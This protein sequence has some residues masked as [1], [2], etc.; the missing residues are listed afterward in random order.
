MLTVDHFT[1]RERNI[2]TLPRRVREASCIADGVRGV[3]VAVSEGVVLLAT[4]PATATILS[5][6]LAKWLAE[7][8]EADPWANLNDALARGALEPAPVER[9][10]AAPEP[11]VEPDFDRIFRQYGSDDQLDQNAGE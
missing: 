2:L 3:A 7:S 9:Y 4:D 6:R 8:A 5:E 1:I 10:V 11:D